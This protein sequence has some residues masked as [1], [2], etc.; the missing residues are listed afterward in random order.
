MKQWAAHLMLRLAMKSITASRVGSR[1]NWPAGRGSV[2]RIKPPV[3]KP[4]AQAYARPPWRLLLACPNTTTMPQPTVWLVEV[5]ADLGQH[6]VGGNAHCRTAGAGP[7]GRQGHWGLLEECCQPA[8]KRTAPT[9]SVCAA[10]AHPSSNPTALPQRAPPHL[11]TSGASP[12]APA[13]GSAP[14]P[15]QASPPGQR[16]SV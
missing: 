8:A 9:L 3:S 7:W 1:R 5:A 15:A 4:A 11:S 13:P 10:A 14:P 6:A 12:A 2:Q 16:S